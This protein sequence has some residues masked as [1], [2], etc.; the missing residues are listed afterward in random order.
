MRI[1]LCTSLFSV[2]SAQEGKRNDT[3]EVERSVVQGFYVDRLSPFSFG[4][5]FPEAV[6]AT[7][8]SLGNA[9]LERR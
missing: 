8:R 2:V 3:G 5:C 4:G 7:A 9:V 6:T 1:D